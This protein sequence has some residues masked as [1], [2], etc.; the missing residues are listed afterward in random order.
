MK[1]TR[2][3]FTLIELLMVMVLM[4]L[5]IGV[6]MP[7]F[8]EAN[9]GKNQTLSATEI[10]GQLQIARAYALANH[11]YTAVIFPQ[12]DE[13]HTAM[14][15]KDKD[16][17]DKSY[18]SSY[19]N[20][21]CRIAIVVKND[22]GNFYF[23][24]W[25]PDGDWRLLGK[26]TMIP[27]GTNNFTSSKSNALVGVPFGSLSRVLETSTSETAIVDEDFST[28]IKRYIVFRPNGQVVNNNS[29]DLTIRITDGGYNI[30]SKKLQLRPRKTGQ[31]YL[32]MTLNG[33]TGKAVL[34]DE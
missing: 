1:R 19:Y 14:N 9:K 31:H 30:I 28:D 5:L 18:V 12:M 34:K 24:C 26:G 22:A 32:V 13:I 27:D 6:A 29:E 2:Q 10:S 20:A 33:M 3:D 15:G 4:G 25:M 8:T 23:V 11:C 17:L 7:A 21:S 16:E